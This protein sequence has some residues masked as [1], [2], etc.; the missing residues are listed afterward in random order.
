MS[1]RALTPHPL[2]DSAGRVFAVLAGQPDNDAYRA[3]VGRTYTFIED[4]GTAARFPAAMR[5]H[6]RS[7]FA[8]VNVGLMMG[9]GATAPSWNDNK[10][11]TGLMARLLGNPD[12]IWM[13]N[14]TSASFVLWAPQLYA[15]YVDMNTWLRGRHSHLKRPFPKSV[16]ASTAFNFGP[17]VWTFKHRDVCNL[18]F[19]WC[20][21][22]LLGPFNVTKDGHLI[23]WDLKLIVEF[24]AG[25]LILPL[26][27]IAHSNILA[28]KGEERIS[29]MQ[30]SAGGLFRYVDN[31]FRMQDQLE[32]ED[33]EEHSRLMGLKE[34]RWENGLRMF[35]TVDELL[36]MHEE[37]VDDDE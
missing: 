22:Q 13:A 6:R 18:P 28:E 17:S 37:I 19:G 16:F 34:S 30:F 14:F 10:E 29:F 21:V 23:L 25:T 9:K 24:P 36:N 32:A 33:P 15:H 26:A 1:S 3:A 2:V 4:Q 20:A 5:H 27:T 7:L 8:A 31:G 12:I 11:Y 35:S